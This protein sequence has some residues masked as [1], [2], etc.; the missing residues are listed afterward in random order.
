[1][2]R[3]RCPYCDTICKVNQSLAGKRAACSGCLRIVEVPF[4]MLGAD[5]QE[6]GIPSQISEANDSAQ[7]SSP[8]EVA[9]FPP[10]IPDRF[11]REVASPNLNLVS[12]MPAPQIR[13]DA[14]AA[15]INARIA[16][17]PN[18]RGFEFLDASDTGHAIS[19]SLVLLL[20]P[21]PVAVILNF[22]VLRLGGGAAASFIIGLCVGHIYYIMVGAILAWDAGRVGLA[23]HKSFWGSQIQL[24]LGVTFFALLFV[25][26]YLIV[27]TRFLAKQKEKSAKGVSNA[28]DE[29]KVLDKATRSSPRPNVT[30]EAS[31]LL[32]GLSG[33]DKYNTNRQSVME[34]AKVAASGEPAHHIHLSSES[35]LF[36]RNVITLVTR[37]LKH[38]QASENRKAGPHSLEGDAELSAKMTPISDL[39][40]WSHVNVD[41]NVGDQAVCV[42]MRIKQKGNNQS[43]EHESTWKFTLKRNK[44]GS[45]ELDANESISDHQHQ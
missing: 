1:M 26:L 12:R 7:I 5:E 41:G 2:I 16:E 11:I 39:V 10:P 15:S 3:F 21:V 38:W 44:R 45:Y 23:K 28:A 30:E 19:G 29:T 13:P 37:Q 6:S 34:D 20:L 24:F 32:D 25:P 36:T 27:R 31:G 8:A 9:G 40:G 4:S 22:I 18:Q 33:I 43:R 14:T 42:Y 17:T 35:I